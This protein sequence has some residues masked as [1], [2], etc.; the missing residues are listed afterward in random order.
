L[1][2]NGQLE[3]DGRCISRRDMRAGVESGVKIRKEGGNKKWE[4]RG[5][6]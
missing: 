4:G 1:F 5:R 6:K 2:I 3:V